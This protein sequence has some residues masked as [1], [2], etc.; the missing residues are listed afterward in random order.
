MAHEKGC[1]SELMRLVAGDRNCAAR[2]GGGCAC[3]R[4]AAAARPRRRV[5]V[6]RRLRRD[7]GRRLRQRTHRRRRRRDLGRRPLRRRRSRSTAPTT[8]SAF[9][10]SARSTTPR[11]T[12][13]AWVQKSTTE[14]RRRDRRHLGR[15]TGRCSGSTTS[16]AATTLTLGS[17]LSSYLDSGVNPI[18]GQWQHLAATFDGTTARFYVDGAEVASRPVSGS[19]GQLEHVADRRLRQRRRRLL[20]RADRR[21]PRLRPRAQ[22]RPRS[23]P[24]AT[25]RSG[26]PNPGAPT[27]PGN[28]TVTGNTQ[29]SVSLGWTASTDDT[30]VS[31]YNIYVGRRRRSERRRRPRSRSPASPARRATARGRGVRRLRQHLA[32]RRRNRIHDRC[33]TRRR[34]SSPHTRSTRDRARS[35]D[36]ASGNG[37][38]GHDLRRDAG[39]PAAT[40]AGSPST[41]STTTSP[42]AHSARSTTPRFT[43]EAWVQKAGA[44]KDVGIVGTWAGNGPMLWVDHLAGHHYLTLGSS[45]ST[46]LDS[47]RS[48]APAQWQHLAATFDGATARYYVDG[49]QVASRAVRRASAART[50]GGS[51]PTAARRR[52]LRRRGRRRPHLQPRAQRGRDPVRPRPRR[53]PPRGAAGHDAAVAARNR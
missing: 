20:R 34:G 29:T 16:R 41:A 45:L 44:K 51:A 18:V 2:L 10:A 9:R 36:D 38:N 31:G 17:S 21:A 40:A 6:R 11:F 48:P 46:Y 22:C 50:R 27:T 25:S 53:R 30:G 15:Q 49:A 13:E 42:S 5:R 28:L 1:V 19:V 7:R 3:A 8:T 23:R 33:A 14:E 47:G 52:L 12:L 43:L 39:L 37:H 4:G 35:A 32:A 24:T 26:S